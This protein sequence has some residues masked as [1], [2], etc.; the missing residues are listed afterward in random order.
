MLAAHSLLTPLCL[1]S[2][3]QYPASWSYQHD[4]RVVLPKP[5]PSATSTVPLQ[6]ASSTLQK[7]EGINPVSVTYDKPS[8]EQ[9]ECVMN[10]S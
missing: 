1:L 9:Q 10:V 7:P 4:L 5:N 6:S 3:E 8:T 2:W